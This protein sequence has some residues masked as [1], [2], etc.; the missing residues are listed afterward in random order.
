MFSDVRNETD[1]HPWTWQQDD[2]RA[3]T[4]RASV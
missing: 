4:A 2:A 3:G 1:G